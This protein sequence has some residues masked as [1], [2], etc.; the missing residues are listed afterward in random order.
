MGPTRYCLGARLAKMETE[1]ALRA[2]L[3]RYLDLRLASEPARLTSISLQGYQS[4]PIDLHGG[5]GTPTGAL[6]VDQDAAVTA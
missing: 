6:S 4:L 2:L 5:D 1:I 3:R